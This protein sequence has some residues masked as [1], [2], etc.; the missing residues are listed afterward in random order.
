MRV[1]FAT[2]EAFPLI[3][4]GG[5]ADVSGALPKAIKNL[6]KFG[7]DIKIL[8]PGYS[9]VLA[10]LKSVKPFANIEVLGQECAL[11]MGKMPDSGIDVIAIQNALLYERMGGPYSDEN[12]IDWPDNALRF[13]VLSRVASLLCSKKTPLRNWLP[14]IIHCNDWQTGL[15]PAYMKLVDNSSVKSILSI[16]NLAFQGNFAASWLDIL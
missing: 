1:L 5:L 8:M 10:K 15:A 6:A 14:S 11:V 12:G 4:T 2:S 16:H 9:A 7:G 13:A 3:K